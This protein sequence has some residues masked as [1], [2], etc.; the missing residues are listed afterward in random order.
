[1]IIHDCFRLGALADVELESQVVDK[2]EIVVLDDTSRDTNK[3]LEI[4]SMLA[5]RAHNQ[6][7]IGSNPIPDL[8]LLLS[9]RF[10]STAP[11]RPGAEFAN[12]KKYPL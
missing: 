5:G 12:R 7:V 8:D 9:Q 10:G 2:R 6:K 4:A 1:L 11:A 3:S